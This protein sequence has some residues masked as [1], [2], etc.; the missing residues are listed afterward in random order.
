MKELRNFTFH[1]LSF[2]RW[3]DVERFF[4]I[5]FMLFASLTGAYGQ[6]SKFKIKEYKVPKGSH[7]PDVARA[8]DGTVVYTAQHQEAQSVLD[9]SSG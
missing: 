8:P 5:V 2:D 3:K 7:P 4:L 1:P 6:E 9:A